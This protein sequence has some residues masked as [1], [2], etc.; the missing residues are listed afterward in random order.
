MRRT[1]SVITLLA[2]VAVSGAGFGLAVWLARGGADQVFVFGVIAMVIALWTNL[3]FRGIARATLLAVVLA[4]LGNLLIM[5]VQQ[6]LR[7]TL[8]WAPSLFIIG[9]IVALPGC[10]T[11]S[12]VHFWV[13]A[14]P[15]SRWRPGLRGRKLH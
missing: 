6:G 15:M 12:V 9:V 13:R 3:Y 14:Y 10:F 7:V 2:A 5:A 8:G 1:V 11:V 4:S